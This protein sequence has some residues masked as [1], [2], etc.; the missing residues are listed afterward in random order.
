M[1]YVLSPTE[2]SL[3]SFAHEYYA[4]AN[5]TGE[6]CLKRLLIHEAKIDGI[7]DAFYWFALLAANS[8]TQKD[9]FT[10]LLCPRCKEKKI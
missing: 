4:Y 2:T 8:A 5:E 1:Y 7:T 3:F 10:S 9:S 6:K